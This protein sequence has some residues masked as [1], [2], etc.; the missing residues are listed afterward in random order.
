MATYG[1][2]SRHGL[3]LCCTPGYAAKKK[4]LQKILSTKALA[5]Q[6]FPKLYL[7]W[8]LAKTVCINQEI[9]LFVEL[10]HGYLN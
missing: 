5:D 8:Y 4:I 2:L 10:T 6:L 9:Y 1:G 7:I 3:I